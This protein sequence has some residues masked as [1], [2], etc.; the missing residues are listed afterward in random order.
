MSKSDWGGA[1]LLS[2]L[3]AWPS[4]VPGRECYKRWDLYQ[5]APRWQALI[6][7]LSC[8]LSC[9]LFCH[10]KN[11]VLSMPAMASDAPSAAPKRT[12]E[13][14]NTCYRVQSV[15]VGRWP[16]QDT[17]EVGRPKTQTHSNSRSSL[18]GAQT[19]RGPL[20]GCAT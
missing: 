3:A 10:Q 18:P 15:K 14:R 2:G 9:V 11:T 12:R 8:G 20:R 6:R 1:A 13:T 17:N 7:G 4:N 5:L 19:R 16:F